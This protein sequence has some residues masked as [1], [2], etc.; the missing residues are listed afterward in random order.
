MLVGG[1]EP[2]SAL[3]FNANAPPFVK[4]SE[5]NKV[6]QFV[7]RPDNSNNGYTTVILV[8]AII[9]RLLL[10]MLAAALRQRAD[11]YRVATAHRQPQVMRKS[12]RHAPR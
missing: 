9:P 12:G 5:G 2:Q 11:A 6:R 8:Y 4:V 3:T 7:E 1:P 10:A